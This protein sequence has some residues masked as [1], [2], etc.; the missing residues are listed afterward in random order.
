MTNDGVR[1]FGFDL[2]KKQHEVVICDGQGKQ[3]H[4]FDMPR[5]R[6]GWDRLQQESARWI[7]E[8]GQGV[9]LVEAAQSF[10]QEVIHPLVEQ[11][12]EAYLLHPV[13]CSDRASFTIGTRRP[14]RSMPFRQPESD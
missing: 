2:A 7:P 10:W 14:I 8:G 12:E 4:R 6:A 1:L 9:Y 5:G 3:L 13:K 11:G